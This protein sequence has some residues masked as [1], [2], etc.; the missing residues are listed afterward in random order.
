MKEVFTVVI[1]L[2]II[3]PMNF[4]SALGCPQKCLCQK[5]TVRCIRQQLKVIPELPADTNTV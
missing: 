1:A 5:G 4:E 2:C 3:F